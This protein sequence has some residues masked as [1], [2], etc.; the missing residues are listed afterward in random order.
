MR[1]WYFRII[2]IGVRMCNYLI[3]NNMYMRKGCRPVLESYEKAK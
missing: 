1:V 2:G 3:I